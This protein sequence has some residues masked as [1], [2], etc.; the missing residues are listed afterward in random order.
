MVRVGADRDDTC[1]E[2]DAT[3]ANNLN[4]SRFVAGG[5]TIAEF[6]EIVLSPGP[7]RAIALDCDDMA[8]AG[9][10]FYDTC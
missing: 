10:D 3:W 9:R 1:Q 6:A 4:W 7:H 2:A 8:A 5:C